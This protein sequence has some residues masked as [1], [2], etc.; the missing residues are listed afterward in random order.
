MAILK[1]LEQLMIE[2]GPICDELHTVLH[3]NENEWAIRLNERDIFAKYNHET[4]IVTLATDV[5]VLTTENPAKIYRALL[6]Y[7]TMWQTTDGICMGLDNEEHIQLM[8]NL[9]VPHLERGLLV[10]VIENISEK[11]DYW[12]KV[13]EKMVKTS[14][15]ESHDSGLSELSNPAVLKA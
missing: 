11:A 4:E 15:L 1:H 3:R 8:I 6:L 9:G 14:G 12:Q 10:D 13:V 5:A 7:N 2:I